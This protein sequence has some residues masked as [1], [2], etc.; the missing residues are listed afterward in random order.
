MFETHRAIIKSVLAV[1][2]CGIALANQP[3]NAAAWNQHQDSVRDAKLVAFLNTNPELRKSFTSRFTGEFRSI[4]KDVRADLEQAF[5]AYSFHIAKMEVYLDPPAKEYDLILIA[6]AETAEVAAFVWGS[7]WTLPP[8]ISFDQILKGHQ[9]KSKEDALNQVKSLAK[10][11]ADTNHDEV[12]KVISEK[13][14]LKVELLRGNGVFRILEV[15]IDKH[16]RLGR[17]TITGPDG[18]KPRY[19]V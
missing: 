2:V 19:F 18:K 1:V 10:L 4:P 12:G 3:S 9:A 8:S 13:G 11:I 15:K 6:D 14:K 17:L 7:Y 16:L 5:P